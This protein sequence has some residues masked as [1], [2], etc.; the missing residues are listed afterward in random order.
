MAKSRRT[1]KVGISEGIKK[2]RKDKSE[3][4][5]SIHEYVQKYDYIYVVKLL[6]QRNSSLKD[7]RAN[8]EPGRI[9]IGKNKLLQV[10]LKMETEDNT[11]KNAH[12]I[13]TFLR[14]ERG[15]IFTDAS[16]DELKRVLLESSCMEIGRQ[17]SVSDITC[18][19]EPDTELAM[20]LKGAELYM[21]KQYPHLESTVR[22]DLGQNKIILC[23]KGSQLD[24]YQYLL[25]KYLD[26]PTVRF[27]VKPIAYLHKGRVSCFEE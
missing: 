12:E 4:I 6:N 5:K 16:P 9:L 27:E 19:A 26:I 8:L 18:T 11:G 21:R 25:L 2:K 22:S 20:Q 7:L 13:S 3:I 15:L 1:K 10:A 24:K 23:E 14:G 17:G